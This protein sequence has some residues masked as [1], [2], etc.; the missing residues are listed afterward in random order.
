[1]PPRDGSSTELQT[2]KVQH[3]IDGDTIVVTEFWKEIR[4]RLYAIDCPEDG[5]PWGNIAKA[6]LIKMIGGRYVQLETHGND[7]HG[8]ILAT[9]YVQRD[10][11]SE[12][13][14]VNERM[15]M[16]G[17]AW[18]AR[19]FYGDLPVPRQN[20]LDQ[21]EDWAKSKRVGLWNTEQPVPPWMWRRQQ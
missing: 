14:N 8:R 17:H 5:Q 18:V 16:L 3:I 20:K 15:V 7:L 4:V 19:G 12:W 6:G 11:E 2:F 10:R 13:T 1:M 9:I 21:L